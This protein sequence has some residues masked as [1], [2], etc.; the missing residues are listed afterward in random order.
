MKKLLPLVL[1]LL[2]WALCSLALAQEG[3]PLTGTVTLR[4][5][6]TLSGIIKA[7]DLGIM[8]G[9]GVGTNLSGNGAIK[10]TVDGQAQRIPA[11]NIAVVEATWTD[12][13][14]REEPRWEITELK[15]TTRDGKTLSGKPGWYMHATNVSIELPSGETKR[16]HAFP[17]AGPDFN[18]GNLIAKIDL[19]S[20][21]GTIAPAV[22][23]TP[24]TPA[25]PE[26]PAAPTTP[27]T[28]AAPETPAAPA[29]PATPE[30]PA[31]PAAP[32][33]PVVSTP[34]V[35]VSA[36]AGQAGTPVMI[37]VNV[38]GT[39]KKMTI[40]LYVT[41]LE[42]EVKVLPG[43]TTTSPMAVPPATAGQ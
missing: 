43:A 7:A 26:T 13:S 4:S 9:A 12:K 3:A 34:P 20:V 30:A 8:D 36:A 6:Q 25:T 14:T 19:T 15:V 29:T 27:A 21:P 32:A 10:I 24:A 16:V 17:L 18:A 35:P 22:P 41:V 42:G 33:T 31:T 23:A 11:A 38:P 40:L 37:T 1:T 28:P 39:D 2:L 5:G